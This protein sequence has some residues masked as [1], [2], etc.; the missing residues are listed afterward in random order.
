MV[1]DAIEAI[2]AALP[3]T[4]GSFAGS[5]YPL[6]VAQTFWGN[7]PIDLEAIRRSLLERTNDD[8]QTILTPLLIAAEQIEA[9]SPDKAEYF[10]DDQKVQSIVFTGS[11]WRAGWALVLGNKGNT[12]VVR[13]L[14]ERDFMVFTDQPGIEGAVFIG[15]R[16]TSPIYFLQL[17]VRYGLVWGRIAPGKDHEMGH[18]LERDMPGFLAVTEDLPPVK[19]LVTLGLMKLGAPAVV[20]PTF[21]FPYGTRVVARTPSEIVE[22]GSRFPNLRQR[23]YRGEVVELPS[24]CNPAWASEQFEA[25]TVLGGDSYSFFCVRPAKKASAQLT[26]IDRNRAGIGILVEIA[27]AGFSDD[28]AQFVEGYAL[29]ALSFIKGVR[30]R[31]SDELFALEFAHGAMPSD[32]Q[33][34]EA[35][36]KGIRVRFPGLQSIGVTLIYDEETRKHEAAVVRAY[37]EERRRRIDAMTE[38][39]TEEFCVCIE[40]RTFSLVHTCIATPER[41]PMC[42]S[43]TYASIKAAARFDSADVP[44]KRPSEKDIPLRSIIRK[45]AVLDA[46]RGEYQGSNEAIAAMTSGQ[47]SRVFLHSLR[48]H[49]HTSCGCFQTL[50]F[51]IP[52]VEGIGIMLRNSKATEPGGKTWSMLANS[53]GGKQTPG[54]SG[55]SLQYIRSPTFLRGDGGLAN[56]VWVDSALYEKISGLLASSQKVATEKDVSD[57]PSL[58]QFLGR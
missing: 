58:R 35:L 42:A 24:F 11:K 13:L 16:D 1:R 22:R 37:K 17:M 4:V 8:P 56:V 49:P 7:E 5:Q 30:A 18:F 6:P 15:G 23:Y 48:D 44:W 46:E 12:T 9:V 51:W 19:Y 50:A 31:Q 55:V 52:E 53:A 54:V 3:P 33:I 25:E 29:K 45:G 14:A 34:A 27:D 10:L 47:I 41:E 57:V 39:N 20:P 36:I 38:A 2:L 28:I 43:R 26:L 32:G 40:C 21:P